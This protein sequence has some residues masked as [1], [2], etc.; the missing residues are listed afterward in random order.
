MN[1]GIFGKAIAGFILAAVFSAPVF[2]ISEKQIKAC[3]Q[4]RDVVQAVTMARLSGASKDEVKVFGFNALAKELA[5]DKD[6]AGGLDGFN[7]IVDVVYSPNLSVVQL[8]SFPEA[9]YMSCMNMSEDEFNKTI[10]GD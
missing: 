6:L 5:G 10:R 9:V 2:A 7:T 1:K 8:V 4:A 3:V